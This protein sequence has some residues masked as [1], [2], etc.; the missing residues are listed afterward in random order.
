MTLIESLLNELGGPAFT[1]RAMPGPGDE[2]TLSLSNG[3][4]LG[5]C[6]S[7]DEEYLVLSS[8]PLRLA[9]ASDAAR[10]RDTV[11]AWEAR[12]PG[13]HD[14]IDRV[15]VDGRSAALVVQRCVARRVLDLNRL[16]L[17]L[18]RCVQ[19]HEHWRERLLAHGDG[20]PAQASG[21]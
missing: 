17:E 7:S 2:A 4:S 19:R 3:L 13:L 16:Q 12:D 11:I 20:S 5:L 9:S 1:R 10:P 8:T 14:T 21:G 6:M 18:E 15:L